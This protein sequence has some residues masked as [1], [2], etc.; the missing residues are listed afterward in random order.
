[1]RKANWRRSRSRITTC[2]FLLHRRH[3]TIA[4]RAAMNIHSLS[5]PNSQFFGPAATQAPR[6]YPT[7][8]PP[9]HPQSKNS[10]AIHEL[11]GLG[12]QP[13]NPAGITCAA[14]P[15]GLP[16]PN[17]APV[18]ASHHVSQHMTGASPP[19][20]AYPPSCPGLAQVHPYMGHPGSSGDDQTFSMYTGWRGS[21]MPSFP[22][23]PGRPS[24]EAAV[25][26]W[27]GPPGHPGQLGV[28]GEF[29]IFASLIPALCSHTAV[30][31]PSLY[32]H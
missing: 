28:S 12:P 27:P 2:R 9:S 26:M 16:S 25:S 17:M 8:P 31:E 13:A 7:C 3:K 1:M 10:F 20:A 23:G 15:A 6:F 19:S 21:F 30:R 32:A 5:L 18:S 22:T 29:P 11:L 4:T 24:L 14:T